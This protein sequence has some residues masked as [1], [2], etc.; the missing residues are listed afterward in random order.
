MLTFT[1]NR[2]DDSNVYTMNS[3]GTSQNPRTINNNAADGYP[4]Y[5]PGGTLIAFQSNRNGNY[6]VWTMHEN[7]CCLVRLNNVTKFDGHPAWS[8]DG[9]RIVFASSRSGVYDLYLINPDGTGIK[10]FV[11]NGAADDRPDW[12]AT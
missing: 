6:D 11:T 5:S 8:P 7:G 1:S 3:D 4:T 2:K 9:T 12:L 10:P